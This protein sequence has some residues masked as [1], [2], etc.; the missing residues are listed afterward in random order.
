M[1]VTRHGV[2]PILEGTCV[3][4]IKF[5]LDSLTHSTLNSS[6]PAYLRSLLSYHIPAR[7]LR[8]SNTNLLS[9]PRVHT[10]FASRG[11]SVAVPSVWNSLPADIHACSSSHTF[12]RLLKTNCFVQAFSSPKLTQVPQIW[13]LADAV[14]FKGFY[15]LAY[16]LP[17]FIAFCRKLK[18]DL[19]KCRSAFLHYSQYN[20]QYSLYLTVTRPS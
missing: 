14:H 1:S 7:S 6:Q 18:S 20:C 16:F 8:S 4:H 11:F 5:K 12:R 19:V 15:L 13:P 17:V 10:T 3:L 2:V 9:V